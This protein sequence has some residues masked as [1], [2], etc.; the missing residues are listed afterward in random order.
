MTNKSWFREYCEKTITPGMKY[1]VMEQRT[2]V[3]KL[4]KE[5]L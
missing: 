1:I 4:V 2:L 3:E 5:L